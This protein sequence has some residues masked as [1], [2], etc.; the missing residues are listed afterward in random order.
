ML[1]DETPFPD[2]GRTSRQRRRL[3]IM[4]CDVVGATRLS[5]ERDVEAYFSILRAYYDACGPVVERHGGRIVQHQG[6][7]IYVWFG[8]PTPRSDDAV[9]AVRAGL[10]LLLVIRQAS[11]TPADAGRPALQVR[12]AVHSG[13]VLVTPVENETAPLAFGHAPNLTAKLQTAARPGTMVV[14]DDVR[15]LVGDAFEL[16][17]EPA[18]ALADGTVVRLHEV[19]R[20]RVGAGRTPRARKTPLVGRDDELAAL[21]DTWLGVKAGAGTVLAVTGPPGVGKTRLATELLEHA[22]ADGDRVLESVGSGLDRARAYGVFGD[23][24][25]HAAGTDRSAPATVNHALLHRHLVD[26]L[27]MPDHAV[28]VLGMVLA[29]PQP[30]A[31]TALQIDP[32]ALAVLTGTML[33]DWLGRLAS[34][35]G[36]LVVFVDDVGDADASSAAV[37]A[38][39]AGACP[40]RLLMLV[41]ARAATDTPG[42]SPASVLP[43]GPLPEASSRSLA[44]AVAGSAGMDRPAL[45]RVL[46]QAEG[47]PFYLEELAR[48]ARDER[49]GSVPITVTERL[50]ARFLAPGVDLRVAGA[51]AVAGRA[52]ATA[53]LAGVLGLPDDDVAAGLER[54]VDADLVLPPDP[55]EAGYRFRHGLVAETAYRMVLHDERARLHGRF[56]DVMTLAGGPAVDR[57][58]V[59]VHLQLAGRPVDAYEAFLEGAD[60]AR[61][62]GATAEALRGYGRALEIAGSL[63][64]QDVGDLLE[65]R[66]RLRRGTAAF[67]SGGF[68]ADEAVEDFARCA[69]LCRRLGPR[70]EHLS[71]MTGIYTY[72]LLQ[73]DL[74]EAHRTAT[75]LKTW[76]DDSNVGYRPANEL[77]FGVLAFMSGDYTSAAKRLR[78]AAREMVAT[79]PTGDL[80]RPWLLPFDPVVAVNCH[81]APVLWVTGARQ[82]AMEAADRALTRAA[83]L[84]FPDGP[85]STAYAKSYLAWMYNLGG[86]HETAR[87]LADDVRHLGARH[88]YALWESAGEIHHALARYQLERWP[89]VV[90][91]VA[92]NAAV[93]TTIR[94]RVFLPYVLTAAAEARA[95]LGQ[96]GAAAEE[97]ATAAALS[98]ETGAYFFEAERLRLAA[99][100]AGLP[101]DERHRLLDEAWRTA[102]RQGAHL[103][104]LRAA[105]DLWRS[106]PAESPAR[107]A[108]EGLLHEAL[109]LLGTEGGYPEVNDARAALG[110]RGA[111]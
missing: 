104:A 25:S 94:S 106:A 5:R 39:V 23:L 83:A 71:A 50:Q 54:L 77:A 97:L 18:A 3:T 51:L 60:A 38:G 13:E 8:Y 35:Y 29:L 103:F 4:F 10:E 62:S 81:L 59:G 84:P 9:R 72:Y 24:V 85:F 107:A 96:P 90:E 69:E 2:V 7:G 14:S 27:G 111:V 55:D 33:G 109:D 28:L 67:A 20:E 52:A 1:P 98:A 48:S 17:T 64:D 86:H 15:R 110:A 70:P 36:P 76:V 42:G 108:A 61:A 40:A 91:T 16:R 78:W 89:G 41:T 31:A 79:P 19:V 56:A 44:C 93:W 87:R 22:A 6:D 11:A 32:A 37:L 88:G 66:C 49:G 46:R 63:P 100:V 30:D 57:S 80:L 53:E 73:G 43:L 82:E 58:V 21:V 45:E 95:G 34:S 47:V 12:I 75:D 105:L 74:A 92:A 102:C 101:L 68:A 99:G 26:D 65:V